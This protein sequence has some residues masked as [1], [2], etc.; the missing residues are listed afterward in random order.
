MGETQ[1][2]LDRSKRELA[3][4]KEREDFTPELLHLKEEIEVMITETELKMKQEI[5]AMETLEFELAL[6]KNEKYSK[7]LAIQEGSDQYL[8]SE[9]EDVDGSPQAGLRAQEHDFTLRFDG[10][11]Q[12]WIKFKEEFKKTT[13]EYHISDSQ[14]LIR[15]RKALSGKA[16]DHVKYLIP[17]VAN[18]KLIME[19]LEQRFGQPRFIIKNLLRTTQDCPQLSVK[20]PDTILGLNIRVKEKISS[21]MTLAQPQYLDSIELLDTLTRKLPVEMK[22]Q[23][24]QRST[25]IKQ[26]RQVERPRFESKWKIIIKR[27]RPS[28]CTSCLRQERHRSWQCLKKEIYGINGCEKMHHPSLHNYSDPQEENSSQETSKLSSSQQANPTSGS[29][30]ITVVNGEAVIK[31]CDGPLPIIPVVIIGP[32]GKH[33]TYALLDTGASQTLISKAS[34]ETVIK[35]KAVVVNCEVGGTFRG[36]PYHPMQNAVT[37]KSPIVLTKNQNYANLPA[38]SQDANSAAPFDLAA[39]PTSNAAAQVRRNWADITEEVNPGAEDGFTLV[40]S[41]KR[42][43]GSANSPT[44]AAPSSNAGVSRT[45]RRPQSS[46]G[47]ASSSEEHCVYIEHSPELEPFHYLSALDRMLGGTAGVI[48]ITKVNGHQLLGLTN[49]GLAERLISEGHEVEGTLLRAFPFRKRAETITVCNLPFF[50]GDSAVINALSPYGRVTSI[51]PKQMKAGP[52]VYVDGRRDVFITLHEGITIERLPTRL[53]INIKG[54][55]WPAYLSSGIRCSRCHGQ[56]HRRA[57]CPLLAG[58]ANNTRSAPP[59]TPAGV[60]ST[61]TSAPPQRSAAQPPTPAPS[62][63]AMEIPGASPAARAVTPSTAPRPSPPVAPAVPMEEAPPAPPPVTP[64]PSPQAPEGP[65]PAAPTPDVEMSIIEDTSASSASSTKNSTRDGLV[66]FIE[67]NPGVSFAGTD[68]LGLGR[69]EVLYLLSSKTREQKKGPL[70]SPLQSDALAGLISQ[71]LDLRPGGSSNIYKILREVKAELRTTP[72]AVPPTPTLPAPRPSVPTPPTSHKEELTPAMMTPPP[73]A[74]TDMEEDDPITEEE[75][76]APPLPAPRLAEPTPPTPHGEETTLAMATPPP[77]LPYQLTKADLERKCIVQIRDLL[78]ELNY[79]Q[80]L[81]P[82]IKKGID[83]NDISFAFVWR[84]NR[85]YLLEILS[86]RPRHKAILAEFLG[87]VAEHAREHHPLI[88]SENESLNKTCFYCHCHTYIQTKGEAWPAYL[89]SGIRCSRCH[90]QGHRRAICPLLAG[91]ANNTRSAPPATPAGVPSTTTS[92]PPQSPFNADEL[93]ARYGLISQTTAEVSAE[94]YLLLQNSKEIQEMARYANLLTGEKLA[95][96]DTL[97]EFA[98]TMPS[99]GANLGQLNRED[100]FID[101]NHEIGDGYTVVQ[102]KRRRRDTGASGVTAAQSN[103]AGSAARRQRSAPALIPLVQEIRTTRTHIAEA[104]AR[105]ATCTEEQCFFLEYCPDYEPYHYLK[106]IGGLVGGTKNIVQFSKVNGQ[107]LVGGPGGTLLRTFPFRRTSIRIT[108]GNLPFFVRDAVVIDALARYGRVTSIAPK[109]LKVGE[110]D[111][112]DGR[113]EAFI[114]LHDGMTVER[115]PSR[116]EIKIKGEAWPAYLTHG[117]KC[118]RCHG[119]GHRRAN[120][121]LLHGQSTTSRRASPPSITNLPPSTAPGLPAPSPA[122]PTPPVPTSSAVRLSGAQPDA[123]A[124]SPPSTAPRPSTPAPPA[125]SVPV[126]APVPPSV[127]PAPVD[128]AGPRSAATEP[129]PPARPDFIAPCGPLPAQGTF[130]PAT[131]TP[132][133]DM[134]TTEEPSASS[135]A[136]VIPTLSLPAPQ[137]AGPTPSASHKEEPTPAMTPPSPP[138]APMEE[139]LPPNPDECIYRIYREIHSSQINLGSLVD[140]EITWTDVID[141]ILHSQSR[142]PFLARLSPNLKKNHAVFLEAAIERAQDFHPRILSGLSELRRAL[143]PKTRHS[144]FN[145]D[146]LHVRIGLMSQTTAELSAKNQLQIENSIEMQE[147]AIYA[148]L[149]TGERHANSAMSRE[150][151][152]K[153]LQSETVTPLFKTRRRRDT[154]VPGVTAAQP[155]S[156]GSAARRQRSSS[157]WTPRVEE[158]RTTRAHIVEARARQASCTEEQCFYLEYCPDF[159]TY[160]CLKAMKRVVGGPKNIFQFTKMNG[161]Y[162]VG[163]ANRSLAE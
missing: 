104:R 23:C 155:N 14:N 60:P 122:A 38:G 99:S 7:L 129:T 105:Q 15:L 124:A 13:S 101:Q 153:P 37:N 3:R 18:V 75:R 12:R 17:C 140:D 131:H 136:A 9:E 29:V 65:V 79:Q 4:L 58:L 106:A 56:G 95:N 19:A 11:V 26:E 5:R 160:Q 25:H 139:D 151:M 69:E 28:L 53:D 1:M 47:S 67:T 16:Y 55:A 34:G 135:P 130:G 86:P 30:N 64:T 35:P 8:S 83:L 144:P 116:F 100:I 71:F 97:H 61:T 157:A 134:T 147:S 72:A 36:A 78:E 115:L 109:Q 142:A 6:L 96:S 27:T 110:F 152:I 32:G 91:L 138:P 84:E 45:I 46:A 40:Q 125:S 146:Q 50:V 159:Q 123:R 118:S 2:N 88:Q 94:N 156:A 107:Y 148:N 48:Q 76:Y 57:I 128:P 98:S 10:A 77:P 120:C 80:A 103:S 154:G 161:H 21:C 137:P 114:L 73:P 92:A 70:L 39:I 44:T 141:A 24:M 143:A 42:R 59:A 112:T 102:N 43:R 126:A 49:R 163:L 127:A 82:L 31:G 133:V 62:N 54:E 63:P 90:G 119:Q 41:R 22:E 93:P 68:A 33:R 74:P 52:Y 89:S 108:I 117:I 111:F 66:A 51:A 20:K 121:P 81:K 162:L 85:E 113:R 87:I 150:F 149:S 145:A 132:D 158:I